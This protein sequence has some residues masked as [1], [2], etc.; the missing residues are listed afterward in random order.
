[1]YISV[2]TCVSHILQQSSD[3]NSKKWKVTKSHV[4]LAKMSKLLG[5]SRC[6]KVHHKT[7]V[8]VA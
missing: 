3:D 7:R 6:L 1:M 8:L 4:L 5:K 2:Q